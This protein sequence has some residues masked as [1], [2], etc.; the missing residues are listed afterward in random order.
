MSVVESSEDH[1]FAL[2]LIR[3]HTLQEQGRGKKR[4]EEEAMPS[5]SRDISCTIP[6]TCRRNVT[7]QQMK[8]P[9]WRALAR[10]SL[11][12]V[13]TPFLIPFLIF[14]G[15]EE[16]QGTEGAQMK[17]ATLQAQFLRLPESF[18]R[19]KAEVITARERLEYGTFLRSFEVFSE[20]CREG[21]AEGDVTKKKRKRKQPDEG[22]ED[23][24]PKS[25]ADGEEDLDPSGEKPAKKKKRG[26]RQLTGD[27]LE[28]RRQQE[29][30]RARRKSEALKAT[31]LLSQVKVEHVPGPKTVPAAVFAARSDLLAA[32][33]VAWSP[34][35]PG[36][37][38]PGDATILAV[39]AMSGH[40]TLWKVSRPLGYSAS[41]AGA[42][43]V[44]F[45]GTLRAHD[46]WVSALGWAYREGPAG[47][48]NDAGGTLEGGRESRRQGLLFLATG[49]SDGS[50]WLWSLELVDLAGS[51]ASGGPPLVI[52]RVAQVCAPS[53]EVV[54]SLSLQ[55]ERGVLKV[56]VAKG[57]GELLI[58]KGLVRAGPSTEH[59]P[60]LPTVISTRPSGQPLMGLD[61][62]ADGEG[63]FTCT[64][65]GSLQKWQSRGENGLLPVTLQVTKGDPQLGLSVPPAS[66]MRGYTGLAVSPNGLAIAGVRT[67]ALGSLDTMYQAKAMRGA[68]Q[69]VLCGRGSG[70]GVK[71]GRRSRGTLS[72]AA[73]AA[74]RTLSGVADGS[75]PARD[76]IEEFLP[77][78]V[79]LTTENPSNANAG[80]SNSQD[81]VVNKKGRNSGDEAEAVGGEARAENDRRRS[82][83]ERLRKNV[84]RS[85]ESVLG[86][87]EPIVLWDVIVAL[88][89][90][91]ADALQEVLEVAQKAARGKDPENRGSLE[92]NSSQSGGEERTGGGREPG[93]ASSLGE[94]NQTACGKESGPGKASQGEGLATSRESG[95]PR[96]EIKGHGENERDQ[97]G[98]K[99]LRGGETMSARAERKVRR[100]LQVLHVLLRKLGR[101]LVEEEEPEHSDRNRASQPRFAGVS[102]G[103]FM[104]GV[105][106]DA[107]RSGVDIT[108]GDTLGK[109]LADNQGLAQA[110]KAPGAKGRA[111]PGW[112]IEL[113]QVETEL[114]VQLA[115]ASLSS[116]KKIQGPVAGADATSPLLWADWLR[117]KGT[118]AGPRAKQLAEDLYDACG[119]R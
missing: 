41:Q 80:K 36:R 49:S 83:A 1:C 87:D 7:Q 15:G 57:A 17:L 56:A 93:L 114:R 70:S 13:S 53:G 14:A 77:R 62:A 110:Q 78:P 10:F 54:S 19:R 18:S 63:V 29:R 43:A 89:E 79:A 90:L 74:I 101:S 58:W 8:S 39:G 44:T 66:L 46:S 109:Q 51:G 112:E 9:F 38:P 95:L 30:E 69:V 26:P 40:V 92:R 16:K 104:V 94:G 47:A 59:L 5:G 37:T 64:Q 71:P 105:K 65:E 97:N 28:K 100:A 35:C 24:V 102:G 61:W 86:Q 60:T 73:E 75:R 85:V 117:A 119:V 72:A 21:G 103:G 27:A 52:Q 33:T 108:Q 45:L 3:Y 22:D 96:V 84:M 68:L 31:K 32:L 34:R 25:G 98:T 76:W 81:V 91:D 88:K 67:L 20:C 115:Q 99:N 48:V 11:C 116:L 82:S 113:E 107:E 50:V 12:F 42:T 4:V 6:E 2:L 106:R 111:L 23:F 55:L 118:G